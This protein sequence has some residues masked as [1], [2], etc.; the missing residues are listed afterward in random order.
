MD[1]GSSPEDGAE[2][3][4][5]MASQRERIK[6]GILLTSSH[7]GRAA[8]RRE[9]VSPRQRARASQHSFLLSF[10]LLSPD[11]FLFAPF[12]PF[13]LFS[14]SSSSLFPFCLFFA[15]SFLPPSTI[16]SAVF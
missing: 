16:C 4:V 12:T 3:Q 15:F 8:V 6:L 10:L 13:S 5:Q 9:I 2:L 14:L 1:G 11:S 7:G